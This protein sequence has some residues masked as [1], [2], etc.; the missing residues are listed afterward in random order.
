VGNVTRLLSPGGF[1]VVQV[2]IFWTKNKWW[3]IS[4]VPSR[5]HAPSHQPLTIYKIFFFF[6][7]FSKN[8]EL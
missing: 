6:F 1:L 2:N 4:I 8:R 5:P 7:F 3:M